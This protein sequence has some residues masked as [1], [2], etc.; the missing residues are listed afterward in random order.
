MFKVGD[1]IVCIDAGK[2]KMEN[3]YTYNIRYLHFNPDTKNK[4]TVSLK[5]FPH[6]SYKLDRFITNQEY[7]KRKIE[8]LCLKLEKK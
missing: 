4:Y 1:K 5:E 2:T 8:K 6:S 7:R 3:N